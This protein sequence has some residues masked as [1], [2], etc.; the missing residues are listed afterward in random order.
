MVIK[1]MPQTPLRILKIFFN[2]LFLIRDVHAKNIKKAEK[3]G[4]NNSFINSH[5][6]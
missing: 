1:L 5:D 6:L 2:I 3:I 4:K